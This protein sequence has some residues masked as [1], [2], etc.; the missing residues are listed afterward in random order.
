[1]VRPM[2]VEE[3]TPSAYPTSKQLNTR[4]LPLAAP[5]PESNNVKRPARSQSEAKRQTR[6]VNTEAFVNLG[7][8]LSGTRAEAPQEYVI[9]RIVSH[10]I[11]GDQE[12]PSAKIEELTYRVRWYGCDRNDDTF[13]PIQYFPR[14]KIVSYYER[15]EQPL[16]DNLNKAQ[17]G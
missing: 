11:N 5:L 3:L 15:I 7:T 12:H 13:E 16:P 6:E 1:M 4:N 2:T 14:N 9:D 17:Q 10:G 8:P